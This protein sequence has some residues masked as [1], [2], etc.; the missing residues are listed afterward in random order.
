MLPY[1]KL[2][3]DPNLKKAIISSLN[4]AHKKAVLDQMVDSTWG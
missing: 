4:T 2:Q 3:M 1:T